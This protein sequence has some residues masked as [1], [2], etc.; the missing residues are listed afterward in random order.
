[1][2]SMGRIKKKEEK[3]TEIYSDK[4]RERKKQRETKMTNKVILVI[5]VKDH[6]KY[7]KKWL[8]LLLFLIL[9]CENLKSW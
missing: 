7:K 4:H 8:E 6:Q 1:M 3:K 9:N 2:W 5:T